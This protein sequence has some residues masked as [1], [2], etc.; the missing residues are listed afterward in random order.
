MLSNKPQLVL[1]QLLELNHLYI[2]TKILNV[3]Q[4]PLSCY[5]A[6]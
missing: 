3:T 6:F 1:T 5:C 2:T 4:L